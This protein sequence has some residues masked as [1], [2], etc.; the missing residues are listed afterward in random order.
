MGPL[1]IDFQRVKGHFQ[2]ITTNDLDPLFLGLAIVYVMF[3]YYDKIGF[4]KVIALCFK[5]AT[6]R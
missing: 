4:P 1:F 2:F 6:T 5:S 3:M